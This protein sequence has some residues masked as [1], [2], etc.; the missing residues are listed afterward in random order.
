MGGKK[1]LSLKQMERMHKKKDEQEK[2]KEKT[3]AS[4]REKKPSGIVP[5][6]PKNEKII[7]ELKKMRVLTPYTVASR[8]NIRIS[9]AKDFLEHLE[10][11]GVIQ[12]VSGDHSIKIYKAAD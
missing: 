8:L 9:A 7:G 12:M 4:A 1:K 3:P 11:H 5:P 6:D 2:R 10:E